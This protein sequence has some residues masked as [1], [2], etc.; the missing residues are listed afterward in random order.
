M[1]YGGTIAGT[2]GSYS[3]AYVVGVG[4]NRKFMGG[5]GIM[6]GG[7]PNVDTID[8]CTIGIVS[9]AIDFGNLSVARQHLSSGS[10]GSRIIHFGGNGPADTSRIDFSNAMSLGDA[11]DFGEMAGERAS[12][13]NR[14]GSAP[15]GNR[16]GY[17]GG[18]SPTTGLSNIDYVTIGTFGNS[19]EYGLM[20]GNRDGQAGVSDGVRGVTAGGNPPSDAMEYWTIGRAGDAVDFG[21]LAAAQIFAGSSGASNGSRGVFVGGYHGG[22][23]FDSTIQYITIGS[24]GDG[25]DY[26][27]CAGGGNG[28]YGHAVISDGERAI[29]TGGSDPG[30]NTTQMNYFP[31]A[32]GGFPIDFGE[33]TQGRTAH[34]ASSGG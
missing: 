3:Q 19:I 20:L 26:G 6:S 14:M 23:N 13:S 8:Y 33:L 28:G 30:G 1:A 25:V 18:T 16:S 21:E 4:N 22:S 10:N 12:G 7:T 31:I 9:D 34:G 15:D 11:T 29:G 32:S 5:R 17:A 27:E 24:L 2:S